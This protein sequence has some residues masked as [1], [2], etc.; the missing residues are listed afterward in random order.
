MTRLVLVGG[1][2]AHV[3][4]LADLAARPLPGVEV[5]L[6]SPAPSHHYS[7]MV[8]GFLQGAYAESELTLDLGW[9]AGRAGARLLTG[10]ATRIDVAGRDVAVGGRVFRSTSCRW[11]WARIRPGSTCPVLA[12]TR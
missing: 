4:V 5:T 9:L 8:P 12:S 10:L 6:V 7:G 1:G 3:H 2:H 11:T